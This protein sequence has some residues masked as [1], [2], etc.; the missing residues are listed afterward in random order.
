MLATYSDLISLPT[1]E[2]RLKLAHDVAVT[3]G[4]GMDGR[5]LIGQ[6]LKQSAQWKHARVLVISRD[7]GRDLGHDSRPLNSS[8]L[9]HHIVPITVEDILE[10]RSCVFDLN[11]LISTSL[12]THNAIHY[13][14]PENYIRDTTPAERFPGDTRLW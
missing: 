11:N 12:G 1:F 10:C 7:G 2:E 5:R 6:R 9:V 8:I 4:I 3:K 14:I 13:A